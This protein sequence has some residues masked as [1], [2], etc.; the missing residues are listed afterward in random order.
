MRKAIVLLTVCVLIAGMLLGCSGGKKAQNNKD[1]IPP[2]QETIPA[3]KEDKNASQEMQLVVAFV[4]A[5]LENLKTGDNWSKQGMSLQADHVYSYTMANISGMRL[6]VDYLLDAAGEKTGIET[7]DTIRYTI[8]DEIAALNYSSPYPWVFEGL[9]YHAQ[10][11]IEHAKACYENALLNPDLNVKANDLLILSM[12]ALTAQELKTLKAQLETIED[13][14][15]E[16]YPQEWNNY[17]RD[18]YVFSDEYLIAVSEDAMTAGQLGWALAACEQAVR[19]NPF[20][21]DNFFACAI[22]QLYFNDNIQKTVY[23]INE[24]LDA[25]PE[26]AGLTAMVDLLNKERE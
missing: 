14:L 26:H 3:I 22:M 18:P 2:N 11:D 21:G 20:N 23:Y 25:D 9:A 16:N 19:V 13:Q 7:E 8:W 17:P 12:E 15:N 6:C 24:G 10:G 1:S 4:N 5:Q